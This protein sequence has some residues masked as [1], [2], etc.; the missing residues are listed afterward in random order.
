MASLPDDVQET[1]TESSGDGKNFTTELLSLVGIKANG[2]PTRPDV[3]GNCIASGTGFGIE[4][5]GNTNQR[6]RPRLI[7]WR[8]LL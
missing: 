6:F 5:K 1:R 8:D 7:A 4:K 3:A 2:I